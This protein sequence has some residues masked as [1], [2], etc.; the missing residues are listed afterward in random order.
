MFTS[1]FVPIAILSLFGCGG[2][3]PT[4]VRG[5]LDDVDGGPDRVDGQPHIDASDGGDVG[6]LCEGQAKVE[7]DGS[8]TI[9]MGMTSSPVAMGCCDGAILRVHLESVY[10]FDVMA[11]V[12]SWG[13]WV[14]GEHSLETPL[15]SD[16]T[17][18]IYPWDGSEMPGPVEEQALG[19]WVRV[20]WA[21]APYEDP[22]LVSLCAK[23]SQ[24]G[25]EIDGMG[26]FVEGEPVI[27]WGWMNRLEVRLLADPEITAHEAAAQSL[28]SLELAGEPVVTLASI[29]Y[30]QASAYTMHWESWYGDSLRNQLPEVGFYGLPFVVLADGE[31]VYM[32]A[33][34]S[35]TTSA[36]FDHPVVVLEHMSEWS[37]EIERGWP[38]APNEPDPRNDPRVLE[39]LQEA[40]K[41]VP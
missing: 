3:T 31:R 20:E 9:G 19:G 35:S 11:F 10:G 28:E 24:P 17:V 40:N 12:Q 33:F 36:T 32:G 27:P 25:S 16:V 14:A 21:G 22:V 30:Y 1:L 4:G 41:L 5:E 6:E 29:A 7:L 15:D 8:R 2:R 39:I 13:G 37:A 23:V 38:V 26:V 34:I 18:H